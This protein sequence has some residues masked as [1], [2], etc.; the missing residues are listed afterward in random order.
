MG[1][2]VLEADGYPTHTNEDLLEVRRAHAP[3]D[4]MTLKILRG[5][6]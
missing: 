3:G 4:E 6:I 5:N 1:D 2:V